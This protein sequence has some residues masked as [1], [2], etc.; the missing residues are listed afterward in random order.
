MVKELENQRKSKGE[1]SPNQPSRPSQAACPRRLTGGP[2]LSAAIL[3]RARPPSL[4]RRP[5]GPAYRRQFS[6]PRAPS[7]SV[8]R[9]R[10]ANHRVIAPHAPSPLSAPWTLPVISAPSALAVDQHVRTRA[11]RRISRPRRPPTCLAPFLEPRQCPAHT[12]HL[13]TCSFAL[14]RALPMLPAAVGDPR[15][16]SWP[17]S[18][19]ETAPTLS[20]LRP[21][22][23]RSSSCPI[24]LIAPCARPI[25]PSP[26]LG[27]GGPPC[28]R[29]GRPI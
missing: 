29:G 25:L 8:S 2:R 20:E 23:R 6:S 22:V 16:R 1:S 5:V 28:S 9:A 18:S 4:A 10:S 26:V 17:S 19:P 11:R 24:S 12:P 27:R 15:P 7:L 21:E 13:I 14:S 3:P